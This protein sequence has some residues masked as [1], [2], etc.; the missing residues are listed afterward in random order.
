MYVTLMMRPPT[1]RPSNI[2][3]HT[4]RLPSKLSA[5]TFLPCNVFT[6]TYT[7]HPGIFCPPRG[8]DGCFVACD[9]TSTLFTVPC[10]IM[11]NFLRNKLDI[12]SHLTWELWR[13]LYLIGIGG[14]IVT[15]VW[16]S[17][18]HN[19]V[20][21]SSRALYEWRLCIWLKRSL[22]SKCIYY[23]SNNKFE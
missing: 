16:E 5:V 14:K 21:Y 4:I 1:T 2:P 8:Q 15:V 3:T 18:Y 10:N 22:F 23:K 19:H 20:M 13:Y 11:S 9:M 7:I 12:L 17:L 6:P